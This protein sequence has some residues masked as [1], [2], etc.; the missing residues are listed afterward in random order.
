MIKTASFDEAWSERRY[1][2]PPYP[3][4]LDLG[5]DHAVR[6]VAQALAN[7]RGVVAEAA[8][9]RLIEDGAAWA[10]LW[11]RPA[12]ESLETPDGSGGGGQFFVPL[13]GAVRYEDREY[14]ARSTIWV[15]AGDRPIS[16]AAGPEGVELVGV[17]FPPQP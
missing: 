16:L 15:G 5:E 17:Q 1:L 13:R 7:G 11:R 14:P 10:R 3:A 4:D 2:L 12:G 9:K 8:E 6:L